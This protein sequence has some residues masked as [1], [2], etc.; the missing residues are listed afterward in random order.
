MIA[1][2]DK[3]TTVEDLLEAV[4]SIWSMPAIKNKNQLPLAVSIRGLNLVV[5]KLNNCSSDYAAV[6]A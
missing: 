5:V 6:V 3:N 4:F 1:A 2:T